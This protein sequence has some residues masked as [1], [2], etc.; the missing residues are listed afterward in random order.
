MKSIFFIMEQFLGFFSVIEGIVQ[1]V[2]TKLI[3]LEQGM[4]GLL[5][6]QKRRPE[7]GVDGDHLLQLRKLRKKIPEI[8]TYNIMAAHIVAIGNIV[9][10]IPYRGLVKGSAI[11]FH[12]AKIQYLLGFDTDFAV[13]KYDRLYHDHSHPLLIWSYFSF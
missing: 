9:S 6:K 12:S 2:G 7:Q 3:I 10:K 4:V 1:L 5:W 11:I 8:M 13:N